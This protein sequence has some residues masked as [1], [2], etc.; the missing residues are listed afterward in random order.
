MPSQKLQKPKL[1]SHSMR[2]SQTHARHR[3]RIFDVRVRR[4]R[5]PGLAGT[6]YSIE[7]KTGS[8]KQKKKLNKLLFFLFL[9]TFF[10]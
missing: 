3:I 6:F 9:F 5:Q 10:C 2:S 8:N 1:N 4:E 7:R